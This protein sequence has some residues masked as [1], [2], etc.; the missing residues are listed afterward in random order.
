MLR[1]GLRKLQ[2]LEEQFTQI[3]ARKHPKLLVVYEDTTATPY[4]TDF[5]YAEGF[6]DADVLRV[7][8]ER[9]QELGPRDW[10][11]L[12]ERLFD[13]DRHKDPRVVVSV[14]MFRETL[15]HG[16]ETLVD[17]PR[18]AACVDP[19]STTWRPDTKSDPRCEQS[20]KRSAST[21]APSPRTWNNSE[22]PVD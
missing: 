12:R 5:L 21:I 2:F 11:P 6:S 9:K 1:A 17:G 4:V 7:D 3:D 10:E 20:P 8:S 14:L 16:F 22:C 15:W 19:N 18:R 13:I